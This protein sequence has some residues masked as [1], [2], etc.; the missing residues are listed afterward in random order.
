MASLLLLLLALPVALAGTPWPLPANLT[1]TGGATSIASISPAFSFACDSSAGCSPSCATSALMAAA[2]ERFAARLRPSAA[3]AA[4]P[5]PV[6]RAPALPASA[7]GSSWWRFPGA[8]CDGPQY[9]LGLSCD[10]ANVSACEAACSANAAC[11]GFNTHGVLKNRVCGSAP[12]S[13]LPGAGCGGC[14]DLYLLRAAPEPPPGTLTG[15]H[16]CLLTDSEALGPATDES[17]ALAA[18]N[19]GQ[20]SIT[21][22][23]AF[24]ALHAM[25]SLVQLLDLYG[26]AAGV[27]R[28]SYAPVLVADAPRFAYRGLLIDSSRHFLPL[29]QVLH[30]IDALAYSKLNL[31]HWHLVDSVSFPCGSATFPGL[32]QHGA[33]DPAAVYSPDDLRAAVAYGHAR[34]VRVLPEWDLPG[35]GDWSGVPG[36]MGCADVVDP[37]ADALYDMLAGFLGEMGGIFTEPSMFLGGDEVNFKCWDA[38]PAIAAWLSAH[39][40]TSAQLQQYFWVQMRARVLP[41]LNKTVGV[42]EADGLQIDLSDLPAGAFVNVYQSFATASKT[43][44]AN[45]STVLSIAGDWWYLVRQRRTAQPPQLPPPPPFIFLTPFLLPPLAPPPLARTLGS[46]HVWKLPPGAS[47]HCTWGGLPFHPP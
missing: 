33:Y 26:V 37:T 38:N 39:N 28:I 25:E 11:G 22:A 1:L 15:V 29:S 9:D 3:A 13:I 46:K 6:H 31:L 40:M 10:G 5:P 35:H 47:F 30:T 7:A 27:R 45:K 21:A 24:G 8:D 41:A 18:P 4:A 23:S 17:Y 42:W 14:V 44:A 2:F 20:G 12:G 16:V 32:A 19:D 36:V 34:G 43:L